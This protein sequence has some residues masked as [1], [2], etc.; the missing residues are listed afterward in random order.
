[1]YDPPPKREYGYYVLPVFRGDRIIGRIEPRFD[2]RT[3]DMRVLGRW[4][5]T[6]MVDPVL[7]RLRGFLRTTAG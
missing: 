5:D 1:M 6:S 3:G 4:G 7:E 2:R